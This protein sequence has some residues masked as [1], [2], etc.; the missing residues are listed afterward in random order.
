MELTDVGVLL[1]TV[2]AA[3]GGDPLAA[4]REWGRIGHVRQGRAPGRAGR[5]RRGARR[6]DRGV[7]ARR[8]L[9]LGQGDVDLPAFFAALAESGYT[10]WVVVEQDRIPSEDEPLSSRR[11]TRCTTAPG[12]EPT[13]GSDGASVETD[14]LMTLVV[15]VGLDASA[16]AHVINMR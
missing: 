6:H 5:G 2:P 13:P 15:N 12:C 9:P 4:L 10:G 16:R 8:V 3:G 14:V 11:P 7:G 1:D